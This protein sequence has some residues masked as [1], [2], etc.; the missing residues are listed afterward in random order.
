[1][2]DYGPKFSAGGGRRQKVAKKAGVRRE[3][4]NLLWRATGFIAMLAMAAGVAASFWFGY[5]INSTLDE[6]AM[7][8]EKLQQTRERNVL[9]QR[10]QEELM[11]GER[12]QA[13]AGKRGLYPPAAAQIRKM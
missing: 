12:V 11:A 3:E 8:Q 7:R 1:M 5:Q 6:M 10:H 2:R 13:A 4:R 9:L